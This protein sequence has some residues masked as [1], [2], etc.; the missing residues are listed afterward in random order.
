MSEAERLEKLWAS[1]FGSDYTARNEM[2]RNEFLGIA[3][4]RIDFW[5]KLTGKYKPS[6]VLEVGCGSGRNLN[7]ITIAT[8][9]YGIDVNQYAL[10]CATENVN[11]FIQYGL[12]KDIQYKDGF[13]DLVF[14][15]GVLIHQ[16]EE[17]LLQVM[18][19]I[20]RCS[21]KY[22]LCM[23]YFS[24][25]REEV[26]YRDQ[27]GALFRDNYG[28]RYLDSFKLKLIETGFLDKEQGFDRVTYWLM[29]K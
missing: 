17:S 12:A 23:E 18:S 14:T 15:C 29:E 10:Q 28:K 19:E 20:V 6:R 25:T 26:P 16:P 5:S 4:I 11:G 13:F 21:R 24:E 27:T 1:N 22:V 3:D 8:D 7:C 9:V 2:V